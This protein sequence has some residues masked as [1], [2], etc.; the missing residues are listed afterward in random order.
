MKTPEEF[1]S[2]YDQ[3]LLPSLQGL[4]SERR[5][6]INGVFKWIAIGIIP[7]AIVSLIFM[8]VEVVWLGVGAAIGIGLYFI[9]NLRKI[10]EIRDRFKS[11]VIAKMIKSIGP[12]LT[13]NASQCISSNDYHKS[14][15]YLH[16]INRYKGDDLVT[17]AVGKTTIRFS[18]LLTQN[19]TT[20]R[21]S[22]GKETKSIET[23]F[24]GLFFVADFNKKFAGETIV[25]PDTAES[26]FGSLGT[27]FQKWNMSRDQLVKMEDVDFEKAFAVYSND[28]VEARYILSTSLMQRI[29]QFKEK[30][31]SKIGLSFIDSE[32]FIAVPLK[33]NLFEA[34]FFGSMIKFEMIEGFN[35]YLVLFI[36]IV[37]DLNLNTRIWTKE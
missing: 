31:R 8:N 7:G 13:Y 15:L 17:G 10:R 18:E 35:K 26:L 2:F 11:E 19:E 3:E 14:R 27:M 5:K 32:V 36:G 29:L 33:E 24:R 9:L 23:I 1:R 34:P 20:R 37:E 12:D 16:G 22:N 6:L 25:L 4:E 21:D 30:T 28:Q